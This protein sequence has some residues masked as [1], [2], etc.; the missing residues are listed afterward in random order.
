M[1]R[2]VLVRHAKSSWEG[3]HT[4]RERPIKPRGIRDANVVSHELKK[5]GFVYDGMYSSPALRAWETAA[6]FLEVL[7]LDLMDLQ[8]VESLYDFHGRDLIEFVKALPVQF[9]S[10]LVFG[11]NHAITAVVNQWGGYVTDNVP[12][13]GIVILDFDVSLWSTVESARVQCLFPKQFR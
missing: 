2:L 3:N 4:D 11:H 10:V 1:K 5:K 6:I 8:E 9:E 7:Q 13:S 12:T